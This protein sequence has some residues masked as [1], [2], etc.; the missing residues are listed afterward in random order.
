MPASVKIVP[1]SRR[2]NPPANL[3]V[4]LVAYDGLCTFEFGLA[5]LFRG[6]DPAVIR[7]LRLYLFPGRNDQNVI[8]IKLMEILFP[9]VDPVLVLS[10]TFLDGTLT[11]IHKAAELLKSLVYTGKD[12]LFVR[13]LLQI[14]AQIGNSV[15]LRTIR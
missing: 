10:L 4:V 6:A 2:P 9:V 8:D 14:K 5:E 15:V 7:I 3:G 13:I 11:D 12:R 1:S